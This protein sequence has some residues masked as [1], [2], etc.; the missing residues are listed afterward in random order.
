MLEVRPCESFEFLIP[1]SRSFQQ[2]MFRTRLIAILHSNGEVL[3]AANS[4]LGKL[5]NLVND[6]GSDLDQI[7]EV[8]RLDPALTVVLFRVVNSA[9]YGGAS[10]RVTTIDQAVMRA[11]LARLRELIFN[12][13]VLKEFAELQLPDG[14]ESF[15]LRN[16]LIARLTE[17]I[18]SL[19]FR[20]NGSEYLAGLLQD[21]GI[22]FLA[23]F[24]PTEFGAIFSGERPYLE[25]E[26]ELLPVSHAGISAAICSRSL[27]PPR[28]VNAVTYQHH[29]IIPEI[30]SCDTLGQSAQVLGLILYI[31]GQLAD[32][33]GLTIAN[34][35]VIKMDELRALPEVK[36]LQGFGEVPL[37]TLISEELPKSQEI[38]R[39]FCS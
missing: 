18:C 3:P 13:G 39:A 28:V 2:D 9:V 20:T 7:S 23:T 8:I 26:A 19:F 35:P 22:A 30:Y 11:G 33:C 21:S 25:I 15:W 6:E 17:R 36:W 10:V 14:W 32:S 27:L 29:P 37:E 31:C 12:A 5:W 4:P 16:I 38:H 24:F 1:R 34:S